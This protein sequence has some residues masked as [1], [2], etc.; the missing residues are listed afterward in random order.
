VKYFSQDAVIKLAPVV[1][2]ALDAFESPGDK[3]KA[4]QDRF[5]EGIVDDI[6]ETIGAYL[7]HTLPYYG[8]VYDMRHVLLMGRVTSGRGGDIMLA[9]AREVM[10]TDYPDFAVNIQ[11]PDEKSRRVGQSVAAASLAKI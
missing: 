1:G 5:G 6:F 9:K 7:G 8:L 10:K 11:L 4:V 3:L 2:I